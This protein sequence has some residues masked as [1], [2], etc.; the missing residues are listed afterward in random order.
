MSITR[1]Y[2]ALAMLSAAFCANAQS[3]L[4]GEARQQK[5]QS[6]KYVHFGEGKADSIEHARLI[7]QFYNDQFTHAQ[8]PQAPYFLLMSRDSKIAMGVGGSITAIGAYDWHGVIDGVG[9]TP[10]DIPIPANHSQP[11]A[12][13]TSIGNSSL[14]LTVFGNHD[15]IGAFKFY[16]QAK[17]AG[18]GDSHYFKLKKAYATAG[19]WTLGYANSTFTDPASQPST[20]ETSGPNSEV[21]DTRILVRYMH[22]FRHG[23]TLAVSAETPDNTYVVDNTTEAG[24]TYMPDFSAFVQWSWA[25][26]QH[27]RLAGIVK[28]IRYRDLVEARNRY[29]TGWG[30]NLS[31]VF[32]PCSH[33]TVYGAGY[34]G[35]GIGNMINDLSNGNNDVVAMASAPGTMKAPLS[36]GWYAAMQYNFSPSLFSTLIVSQERILP[37]S[38]MAY[39]GTEYKYGLYGTANIFYNITP[40]WQVGAE[41]NIG[42]RSNVDGDHRMAYRACCL[43]QFNF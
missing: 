2:A 7:E 5:V 22:T 23:I 33:I 34:T 42:K 16:I 39:A 41:F 37:E 24:N 38:G 20:V 40:R 1:V 29:V 8:D 25:S 27:L 10:Y 6:H 31:T 11:N 36:Y 43:A 28:G 9:F 17:F 19:D 30:V 35:R 26:S 4:V 18:G 12:F 32:N 15:R 21:S 14:F 3:T 13:Q